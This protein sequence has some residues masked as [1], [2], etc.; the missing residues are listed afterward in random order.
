MAILKSIA[1]RSGSP[2]IARALQGVSV[3]LAVA[4]TIAFVAVSVWVV[5]LSGWEPEISLA[6]AIGGIVIGAAAVTLFDRLVDLFGQYVRDRKAEDIYASLQSAQF[7]AIPDYVLY[8]RPFASTDKVSDEGFGHM[9]APLRAGLAGNIMSAPDRFE[10][11]AQ[12]E[13]AVRPIG[14]LVGLGAPLEHIGAGRILT[15]DANWQDVIQKLMSYAKLIILL[16]SSREGTLW[17]I[18]RLIDTGHIKRT[19]LI[20]PPNGS[21]RGG[22]FDHAVEWDDIRYVMAERGYDLPPDNRRGAMLFFGTE[23]HPILAKKFSIG[24]RGAMRRFL[25]RA[26]REVSGTT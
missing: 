4:C 23:K 16:P 25:T 26:E 17:E 15:S 13:H 21:V 12:L 3:L 8:L 5:I 18:E 6:S 19:I 2:R 14:T 20:D 7:G 10:L 1:A 22:A 11:E 24:N 9:P